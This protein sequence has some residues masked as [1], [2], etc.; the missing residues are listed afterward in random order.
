MKFADRLKFTSSGTSAATISVG[1]AVAGCFT[2]SDE[3][4]NGTLAVNDAGVAFTVDDG[5]GNFEVSLFTITSSSQIT[6]TQV[7]VSSAGGTTPATFTGSTLTVYNCVP[8]A[9]LDKVVTT[10]DGVAPSALTAAGTLAGTDKVLISQDGTNIVVTTLDAIKAYTGTSTA[11]TTAPSVPSNLTSSVTT[12]SA[13][14]NWNAS[15][16]N[17]GVAPTYEVSKDGTSWTAVSAL[18]YTWNSLTASTTYT[19]QVRA[20]DGSGNKSAAASLSV[21]TSATADT[22]A[23][24]MSGSITTSNTTSSATTMAYT[25]GSDNVGVTRYDV[26]VDTGTA[27]WISNGTNLSY[28]ATG[29]S[30]STTYTLRV[31]C[32]DAAGNISNVLTGSVTTSAATATMASKYNLTS[33]N[34][35]GMTGGSLTMSLSSGDYYAAPTNTRV[36]IRSN[37]GLNTTLTVNDFKLVWIKKGMG[38]PLTFADTGLPANSVN[39]NTSV[40]TNGVAGSGSL[41]KL[42][43]WVDSTSQYYGTFTATSFYM[44]GDAPPDTYNLWVMYSDGSNAVYD[45]GTGTAIDYVCS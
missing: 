44:W 12:T 4:A 26:S 43:G 8:S 36:N 22:T 27:N 20:V 34:S 19:L 30:A 35:A 28:N 5:A 2:L 18:T 3:I 25:A 15:T 31:R 42:G 32:V 11:D 1:A 21:T 29:L 33:T 10:D 40:H 9:W 24:T 37:D 38:C 16:D 13:T 14:L 41:G 7:L 39:G 6:R 45:N 17:S 23:P